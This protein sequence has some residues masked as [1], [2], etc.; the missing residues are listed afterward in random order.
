MTP[1][2][3]AAFAVCDL[4]TLQFQVQQNLHVVGSLVTQGCSIEGVAQE[5]GRFTAYLDSSSILHVVDRP[6]VM[7]PC[8]TSLR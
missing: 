4:A 8:A 5:V 2:L 6:W 7:P 1:I 3:L